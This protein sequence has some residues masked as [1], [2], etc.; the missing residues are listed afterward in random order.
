MKNHNFA[1]FDF[2][3]ENLQ[4]RVLFGDLILCFSWMESNV[5]IVRE[6]FYLKCP[7]PP[8]DEHLVKKNSAKNHVAWFILSCK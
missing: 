1:F 2:F 5:S 4:M 3:F 6:P 7:P 8:F